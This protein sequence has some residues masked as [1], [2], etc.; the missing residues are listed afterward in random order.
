MEERKW[1]SLSKELQELLDYGGYEG[2]KAKVDVSENGLYIKSATSAKDTFYHLDIVTDFCRCKRL[3]SYVTII[4]NE[5]VCRV[6]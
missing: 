5:V 6:H 3:L 4:D 1:K 2:T